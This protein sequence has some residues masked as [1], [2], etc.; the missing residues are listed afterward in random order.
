MTKNL[1]KVISIILVCV[2][3]AL[4]VCGKGAIYSVF[5]DEADSVY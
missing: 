3:I 1:R 2:L 4:P 5:A